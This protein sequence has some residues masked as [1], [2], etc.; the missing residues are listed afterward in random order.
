MATG[1]INLSVLDNV[2]S[3]SETYENAIIKEQ[4][5][6]N[7]DGFI[8]LIEFNSEIQANKLR[9]VKALC[10][11]NESN[12]CA[13]IQ[14]SY[15]EFKNDADTDVRNSVDLGGGGATSSRHRTELSCSRV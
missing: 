4:E 14:Y 12:V 10:I 1:N 9:N 6:D 11:Y 2:F 8:R 15:N 13:E 7:S 5:L 3:T